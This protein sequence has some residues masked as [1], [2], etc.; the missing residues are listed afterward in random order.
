MVNLKELWK[1]YYTFVKIGGFTLGGGYAMIPIIQREAVDVKKWASEEEMVDMIT[2][3]QSMPGVVGINTATAL[4]TKVAGIP[5]ALSATLGMVTPSLIIIILIAA[6]F[7][8]FQKIEMVKQAFV[9]IRAAI[10]ALMFS[11]VVRLMK[12]A[13]K[14][15]FQ[16]I[17]F[18]AAIICILI[19]DIKPQYVLIASA[20]TAIALSLFRTRKGA[21]GQ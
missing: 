2:L 4:G 7:D 10:A 9:G 1:L 5:G 16:I 17:L 12:T 6:V 15:W 13:V 19:L 11:A 18:V 20:G 14:D 21:A 8:E 3:A